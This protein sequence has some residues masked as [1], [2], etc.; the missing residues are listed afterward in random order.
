MNHKMVCKVLLYPKEFLCDQAAD[1]SI[2]VQMID[3]DAAPLYAD[4]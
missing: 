1:G 3:D 2:A 4:Q